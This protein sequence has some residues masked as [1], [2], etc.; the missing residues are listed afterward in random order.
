MTGRV[1]R[2]QAE[3]LY[4]IERGKKICKK[5]GEDKPMSEFHANSAFADGKSSKCKTCTIDDVAMYRERMQE[6]GTWTAA[7]RAVSIKHKYNLTIE[8]YDDLYDRQLG[9]CPGCLTP[10]SEA[11]VCVDHDHSCCAGPRS[12][13][14][15]VRGLLCDSCNNALGRAK[16]DPQVLLRLASYI[17]GD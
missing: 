7:R 4:D 8:Q 17:T 16:D 9:R 6:N 10:L 2:T 1:V 3:V 12:C 15:C 11:K 13:G 14:K 5:C